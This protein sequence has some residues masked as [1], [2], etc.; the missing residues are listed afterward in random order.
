[1]YEGTVLALIHRQIGQVFQR[2]AGTGRVHCPGTFPG[3]GQEHGLPADQLEFQVRGLLFLRYRHHPQ[4]RI[5]PAEPV[6]LVHHEHFMGPEGDPREP[7][8]ELGIGGYQHVDAPF[9]GK[10]QPEI[11]QAALGHVVDDVVGFPFFPEHVPAIFQI[12]LAGTGGGQVMF[13]PDEQFDPQL[14][15][16]LQQLLVQGG[17]G[18]EQLL[19]GFGD[20]A[21]FR[22]FYDVFDL[23]Q[24]HRAHL[25]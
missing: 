14:L 10:G 25:T 18:N 21:G 7:A 4:V 16:Q 19:G 2:S 20:A 11:S 8:V 6:Q 13:V 12:H 17:L 9:P 5:S 23:F 3:N 22:N 1:M 24:I 15:F